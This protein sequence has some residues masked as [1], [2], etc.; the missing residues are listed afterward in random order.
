LTP[1]QD[2]CGERAY[3]LS[4]AWGRSD[5]GTLVPG[6]HI[7]HLFKPFGVTG[8]LSYT[9]PEGW[10]VVA[11]CPS[12]YALAKQDSDTSSIN[13]DSAVLL[14]SHGKTC[15]DTGTAIVAGT[16]LAFAESLATVPGLV[17]GTPTP[18]TVGGLTG[19]MVD[20][21]T[22]PGWSDLCSYS[23]GTD[24]NG[25]PGPIEY[26]TSVSTF[27]DAATGSEFAVSPGGGA[28]YVLLDHGVGQ[29]LLIEISDAGATSWEAFLAEA[30]PVVNSF[31]FTP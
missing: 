13:L 21:S 28:R 9:V 1:L 17:A 20:V 11:D 4:G 29:T 10:M 15:T 19:V 6:Q 25:S 31:E 3:R 14:V 23:Q 8:Q 22:L 26:S 2:A 27:T 5:I 18:V 16:P 7:S 30:M 24:A 12:C